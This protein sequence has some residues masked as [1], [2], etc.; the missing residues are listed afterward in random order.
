MQSKLQ[1]SVPPKTWS[2]CLLRD[3]SRQVAGKRAWLP[4]DL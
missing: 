1:E 4:C 3:R 2:L